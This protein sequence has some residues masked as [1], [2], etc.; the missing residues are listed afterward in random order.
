VNLSGRLLPF[1]LL[2]AFAAGTAGAVEITYSG[3]GADLNVATFDGSGD[4]IQGVTTL[5]IQG[6][7]PYLVAPGDSVQVSL[8][9]LQYPYAGDLQV[10]LS[11]EDSLGNVLASGDLFNQIGAF[12]PGDPG[13]D[14]QF[15]NSSSIPSGNYSFDSSFTGDLWN[16]AAALGSADSIPNGNYWPTT[17]L[18]N[19]ND[20]LSTSFAGLPLKDQWVLII[21]DDYPPFNGGI[22]QFVPSLTSWSVTVQAGTVVPEPS[23]AML[24]VLCGVLLCVIHGR[25]RE[26]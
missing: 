15:G 4:V 22:E 7:D 14:T 26:Q 23:T 21:Y 9:G 13:Y 25:R 10:N 2:S 5:T 20:N 19:T 6:T 17:A 8:T 18:S 12:I 3:T 24:A 1:F 16:T 11:L